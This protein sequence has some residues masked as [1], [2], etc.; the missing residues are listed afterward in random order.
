MTAGDA[1]SAFQDLIRTLHKK[2]GPVVILVDEYDKPLLG[3][4]GQESVEEIQR[5][6]K[7]FYS[8]I[9]TT[10]AASGSRC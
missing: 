7:G 10:E 8:V 1:A 6:L 2:H 3:H 9:K 4:L 5:V